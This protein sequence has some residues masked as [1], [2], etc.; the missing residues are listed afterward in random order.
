MRFRTETEPVRTSMRIT[1][2]TPVFM[3]GSCFS[4]NISAR[5]VRGGFDVCANPSGTLYNPLSIEAMI[6]ALVAERR[7]T[8]EELVECSGVWHSM[9]HHSS[10][11]SRQRAAVV[12]KVNDAYSHGARALRG[13]GIMIL[14]FGTAWIYTRAG[15][16]VA[17]CHKLPAVEFDRRRLDVD[18]A[19]GAIG[20]AV[21]A[22]RSVNAAL[23]VVL[24]VSPVRHVADGL[25]GNNLSKATLLLACD[26]VC[27]DFKDVIYFPSY[28]MLNDDLRDYRF[29]DADMKHPS[30]VAVD[31]IYERFSGTFMSDDTRRKALCAEAE[32]RRAAHRSLISN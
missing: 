10:F 32:W 14:T 13:A 16:V 19:A 8:E 17:N 9:D 3:A 21:T 29:Y 25:H 30:P 20:R 6:H 23:P 5:L 27:R 28:E 22:A 7:V 1:Y 31:Y 18:E 26:R 24:T 12:D 2:D 15:R 11:S 4:D